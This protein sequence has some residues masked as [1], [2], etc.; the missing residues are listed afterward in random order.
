MLCGD[1][2][3]VVLPP[4]CLQRSGKYPII[5]QEGSYSQVGVESVLQAVLELQ[6]CGNLWLREL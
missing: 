5:D 3:L 1:Q 6:Y 2:D 4:P